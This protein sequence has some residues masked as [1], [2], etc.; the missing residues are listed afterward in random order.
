MPATQTLGQ[1][2]QEARRACD[3]TLRDLA[4]EI[5]VVPSFISD[6]ENGKRN[7]SD[8]VLH[9]IAKAV[10][11]SFEELKA[12][13]TRVDAGFKEL[14]KQDSQVAVLMRRIQSNPKLVKKALEAL[15]KH[16]EDSSK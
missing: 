15:D 12:F 14:V 2:I 3:K 7:P 1:A 10:G 16:S 11:K 6:I 8:G 4:K 5:K 13:D 9:S